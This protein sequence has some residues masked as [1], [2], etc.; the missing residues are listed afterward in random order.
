MDRIFRTWFLVGLAGLMVLGQH[1]V[2]AASK[3]TRKKVISENP[4]L[5]AI[6]VDNATG[7]VLFEDKADAEGYPASVLKLMDLLIVLEKIE[8][9]QLTLQ[10]PVVVSAKASHIGGSRVWLAEK[11]SFTV[12]DMLYAL[13]IQS[14]NDVAVALAEK[15]AGSTDAFV[16]LMNKR[17]QEL[18]MTH[19]VFHSVHGL[20]PGAG[21]EHDVT[22]PRDFALLSRELLKHKD[23]LRYTSTR[24]R[25]FRPDDKKHMV[26]MR[27]HDHLLGQ[28][29]GVDGLKTGYF[30]D[31]GYSIALT[32]ERK[33][34]R[35]IVVVLGS[36]DRKV[37]DAK[38]A[39]LLA[40]G[41]LALP[42]PSAPP[43]VPA[44]APAPP[45]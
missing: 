42:A 13:M 27:N 10:D 5:G 28:V 1:E 31:A 21:Q 4:Y 40:K 34:Q 22:T 44:N 43:P 6:V 35:V 14:A 17:A 45:K 7:K 12:D 8:Q 33:G 25:P 36:V 39:E 19:T 37:R 32:A 11:E 3:P 29:E 2:R 23:A 15:I 20:P 26:I 24:E 9:K 38:A 16:E 41:F 18:G 30:T